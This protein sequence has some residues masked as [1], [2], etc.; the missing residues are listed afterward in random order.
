MLALSERCRSVVRNRFETKEACFNID[1]THL[2]REN[3]SV[4]PAPGNLYSLEPH[5]RCPVF[6]IS[7]D[8]PV[9]QGRGFIGILVYGIET[10]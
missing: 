6:A 1:M 9:H 3:R 7:I 2:V 10:F 5:D 4:N 8:E